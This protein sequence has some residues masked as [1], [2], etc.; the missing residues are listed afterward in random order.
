MPVLIIV[1]KMCVELLEK[2]IL[3]WLLNCLKILC[4]SCRLGMNNSC[5]CKSGGHEKMEISLSTIS[6]TEGI[7]SLTLQVILSA[8]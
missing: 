1:V 4:L 2:N 7:Q 5:N 8:D 6:F 3:D